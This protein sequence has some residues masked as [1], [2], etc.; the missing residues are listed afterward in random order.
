MCGG[1]SFRGVGYEETSRI[2]VF[3]ILVFFILE[4]WVFLERFGVSLDVFGDLV[5]GGWG[6]GI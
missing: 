4:G 2:I 1:L 6:R 3:G 5:F